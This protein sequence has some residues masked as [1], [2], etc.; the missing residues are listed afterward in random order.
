[1]QVRVKV[2]HYYS[3]DSLFTEKKKWFKGSVKPFTPT[4]LTNLCKLTER[5]QHLISIIDEIRK[6]PDRK[7]LILSDRKSHL[8]ELKRL[9]DLLIQKDTE[10]GKVLEGEY[11]TYMYT[12]D[13]KQKE[14]EAAESLA[15]ILFATTG[16]AKEG[17]DIERLN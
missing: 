3:K 15:D 2:F 9:V 11:R 8:K 6:D 4:M 1:K 10:D 12:G 16:L 5:T 14:R 17:L 13:C 7:I